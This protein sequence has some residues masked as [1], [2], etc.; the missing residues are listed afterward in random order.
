[1]AHKTTATAEDC[2]V[3]APTIELLDPATLLVDLNVR[4]DARLDPAFLASVKEHGVL[5]PIVA[6]R[7]AEGAVR[8]R[9]GH[10]RTLAAVEVARPVVPVV[11]VADEA[12]DE[13]A[14]V[15]RIV[16]QW[17]E[18]EHRT[19]LTAAERVGALAQLAAF[20]IS[21][22]QI[23]KRTKTGRAE[24]DAALA[25]AGS[26]LAKA[27]TVRYDFLDLAQAATVAEFESEVEAVKALVAAAKNGQFDHVAQ[28]LRDERAEAARRAELEREL[29]AAGVQVVPAPRH[30]ETVRPLTHLDGPDGEPLT[31][32]GHRDCPGHAAYVGLVHGW[33]DPATGTPIVD[34]D[35]GDE[36]AA[37]DLS[38]D[39]EAGR[40]QEWG[41][42]VAVSYACTAPTAHGHRDRYGNDR[43]TRPL[44]RADEMGEAEREAAREARREVVENNKAWASAQKVR[45]AWLQSFAA[46]KTPP[47]GAAAFVAAALAT[48]AEIVAGMGGNALAAEV[49]G[50]PAGGYGRNTALQDLTAQISEA[51]ALVVVLVQVLAAYEARADRDD[52]RHHRAH[53]ARYLGWLTANGYTLAEVEQR[54]CGAATDEH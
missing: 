15:E 6:V 41:A 12:A 48:D 52:W 4:H 16:G 50:L 33:I 5:V 3:L 2:A 47:K 38:N 26:D 22:A 54:A 11:L 35:H 37:A 30:G 13:A 53:T 34:E 17:A 20:G 25:V 29:T 42:Y 46:R 45:R 19:S 24:V 39:K 14:Q 43:S 8:V 1:M 7:T 28:R 10:R 9:F 51:R 23:A 44:P 18:N 27:A 40:A 49:L 32:Q 31:T 36:D 21:P